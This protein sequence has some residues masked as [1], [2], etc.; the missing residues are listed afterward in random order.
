MIR[1]LTVLL[2]LPGFAVAQD[3]LSSKGR[4]GDDDFYKTVACAAA[5]GGPCQEDLV[6]WSASDA[7]DLTVG[8]TEI[9]D[10]FPDAL[11]PDVEEALDHAIADINAAGSALKMRLV[12]DGVDP[13]ISIH[14]LDQRENEKITGM[15]LN[16]VNGQTLGAAYVHVWWNGAR[17]LTRGVILVAQ[18]IETDDLRSIMLE[19]LVQAT[20]LLTDIDNSW[21]D[22]RSIFAEQVNW[23]ISLQPQDKMAL[24]RHYPI[25]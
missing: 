4:L 20:G 9:K 6:R 23:V 1:L 18:D 13:H 15:S 25:Q 8:I 5:P 21:Y 7:A 22:T 24:Q 14:L 10:G 16:H 17:E 11:K 12:E 19:E 2:L 3:Y